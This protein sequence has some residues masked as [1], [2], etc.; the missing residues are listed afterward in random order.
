MQELEPPAEEEQPLSQKLRAGLPEAE[1][2]R[3]T[4]QIKRLCPRGVA[5]DLPTNPIAESGILMSFETSTLVPAPFGMNCMHSFRT[6]GQCRLVG[7]LSLSAFVVVYLLREHA[8]SPLEG[9]RH[10]CFCTLLRTRWV[11][12]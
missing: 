4:A 6:A 5:R 10:W 7:T 3:L 2:A 11:W 12:R 8:P 1:V 9:S